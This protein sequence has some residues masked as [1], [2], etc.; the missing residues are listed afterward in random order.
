MY[1]AQYGHLDVVKFLCENRSEGIIERAISCANDSGNL[2][3]V[4]YLKVIHV[5]AYSGY[6]YN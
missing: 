6:Y 3:I 4:K 2:E 1:A 5:F